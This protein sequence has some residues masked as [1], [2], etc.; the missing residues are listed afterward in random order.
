[1]N[2]KLAEKY[3]P[4]SHEVGTSLLLPKSFWKA[5]FYPAKIFLEDLSILDSKKTHSITPQ[6]KGPLSQ[7][8]IMQDLERGWTRV[9]GRGPDGYFSYRLAISSIGIVLFLE[10]GPQEGIF[11]AFDEKTINLQPKEELI[12]PAETLPFKE[13][14][15]EKMHFG[16]SKK[17]DWTLVKRRLSIEEILP[18]WFEIG[19]DIPNYPIPNTGNFHFLAECKKLIDARDREK[20]GPALIN[21]FKVGFEGIFSPCPIDTRFQGYF[22]EEK[23]V[24]IE[25]SPLALVGEGARLIRNLLIQEEKGSLEILPCLPKE[26]HAG[27]FTNVILSD[28]VVADI[29]WSKKLIRRMILRPKN[30]QEITLKFQS[31]IDSFRLRAGWRGR[32]TFHR[33][34]GVLSLRA[35]TLYI[36]DRFQK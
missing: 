12:I 16:C 32:G 7:F 6:I 8:T 13:A 36:L 17:Q 31:S 4:F 1:M 11:F 18:I 25:T 26:V 19:K 33:A 5:T 34:G 23:T 10:R 30:D 14:L 15:N 35:N 28:S 24:P 2:I 9:F 27:R 29:E 22:P 21:L 20:I 3:K